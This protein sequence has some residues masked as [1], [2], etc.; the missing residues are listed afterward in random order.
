MLTCIRPLLRPS[1]CRRPVWC[2]RIRLQIN[3]ACSKALCCRLVPLIPS[4]DRCAKLLL[5]LFRSDV[6]ATDDDLR[7]YGRRLVNATAGHQGPNDSRHLVRQGHP[8]QHR[9]LAC[10]HAAQPCA[11]SGAGMDVPF[12]DDA[13]GTDDQQ[14]PERALSCYPSGDVSIAVRASSS[15][16]RAFVCHRSNAAVAPGRAR[17]QSRGLY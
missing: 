15:W 8:H 7:R 13:V 2:S 17:P 14:A 1:S 10:Q 16:V 3:A 12:D 6:L 4:H 11:R 9:R 5:A